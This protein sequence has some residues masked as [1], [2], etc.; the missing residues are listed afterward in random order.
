MA[1]YGPLHAEE[2][3]MSN[4]EIVLS[5]LGSPFTTNAK[6]ILLGG[7]L[8]TGFVALNKK[9]YSEK[10]ANRVAHDPPLGDYGYIGEALGWGYL[11]ALYTL[12][13]LTHGY[14]T[15]QDKSL[16]R[17]EVM[18]DASFYTLLTT[19]AIKTSIKS[20]RPE[21]PDENDSFPSGHASMS[22]AFASVVTAEHGLYWGLPAYAIAS[23]I[24]VSR[25]NDGRHWV[26]DIIAGATIGA[27]YGW[28]VYLNHRKSETPFFLTIL[29]NEDLKSAN[30]L[31]SYRF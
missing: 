20:K 18:M 13:H 4:T 12:G 22:F 8:L 6:Y 29:P 21:F 19:A 3:D 14:F 5:D 9:D 24:S 27:S 30:L 7:T 16:E 31:A 26:H 23:F 15:G 10:A 28:G 11:N 1:F 2:K 25:I 17:A